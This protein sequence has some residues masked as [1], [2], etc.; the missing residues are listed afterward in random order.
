MEAKRGARFQ[1]WA[2]VEMERARETNRKPIGQRMGTNN[3][4]N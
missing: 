2:S 3:F 4:S 1:E